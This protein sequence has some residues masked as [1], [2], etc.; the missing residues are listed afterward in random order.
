MP[1]PQT[2][3]S[4]INRMDLS[5]HFPKPNPPNPTHLSI[6]HIHPRTSITLSKQCLCLDIASPGSQGESTIHQPLTQ[7]S[8]SQDATSIEKRIHPSPLSSTALFPSVSLSEHSNTLVI[9]NQF[10]IPIRCT[11]GRRQEYPE[12]TAMAPGLR[13]DGSKR[14]TVYPYSVSLSLPTSLMNTNWKKKLVLQRFTR[15]SCTRAAIHR[16]FCAK[17]MSGVKYTI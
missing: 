9:I 7:V 14:R 10:G 13:D 11:E 5:S 6:S 4:T 12:A 15:R 3:P 8:P 1:P 17:T 16:T 2:K